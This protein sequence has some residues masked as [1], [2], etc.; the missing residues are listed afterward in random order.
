M[1][2]AAYC[3]ERLYDI[4]RENVVRDDAVTTFAGKV[5]IVPDEALLESFPAF[6]PAEIEVTASGPVLRKR[7]TASLGDPDRPLDEAQLMQKAKRVLSQMKDAPA[8]EQLVELGL[9]GLQD[10]AACKM[11]ADTLW[12]T[13]AD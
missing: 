1:G 9:A 13:C 8:A 5:E 3:R 7:I 11:L 12:N 4:E 2:L 10:K 6:F